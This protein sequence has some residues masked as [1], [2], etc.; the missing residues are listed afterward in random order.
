MATMIHDKDG[1]TLVLADLGDW[2]A[3]WAENADE[4]DMPEPDA[5]ALACS[6]GLMVGGGAAPLF[7]VVMAT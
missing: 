5:L 7:C 1:A 2:H 6:A 4:F 3:F